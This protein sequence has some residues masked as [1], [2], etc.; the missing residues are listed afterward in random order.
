MIPP[1]TIFHRN[2][3]GKWWFNSI[4]LSSWIIQFPEGEQRQKALHAAQTWVARVNRD[5][6]I[7][8]W[9]EN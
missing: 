7:R 9:D 5:P 4:T 6:N 3:Q 1:R 8:K 2:P